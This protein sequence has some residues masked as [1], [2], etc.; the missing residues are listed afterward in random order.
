MIA[1]DINYIQN[2]FG[3]SWQ[4]NVGI[5]G[6]CRS[7]D[8]NDGPLMKAIVQDFMEAI[9]NSYQKYS[10]I[11]TNW[12]YPQVEALGLADWNAGRG[13]VW[14]LGTSSTAYFVNK[15]F[16]KAQGW[17]IG[18]LNPGE[19][20]L[21]I[22]A[23]CG[24]GAYDLALNPDY[25]EPIV[26]DLLGASSTRG[27]WAVIAPSRGT[28]I[29]GDRQVCQA[30]NKYFSLEPVEDIGTAFM[31]AQQE[32]RKGTQCECAESYNLLGDPMA[33][34]P[35][36]VLTSVEEP[37]PNCSSVRLYPNPFNP[38]VTIEY[39]VAQPSI[40]DLAIYNVAGQMA[41]HMVN[42]V[43]Q[44]DGTHKLIWNG[45]D[46]KGRKVSSG[47]YFCRLRI[48]SGYELRKAILLR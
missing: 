30:L 23:N 48:G 18:K 45:N 29:E 1:K 11:D 19:L 36:R 42:A 28:W 32:V 8:G 24:I 35:T 44:S 12:T 47:V 40:V 7:L 31:L 25:G 38:S 39:D 4:H 9:P 10:L 43:M 2:K 22:G 15:F 34:V 26:Q 16:S 14:M 6:F 20:T 46:E 27:A 37:M 33:P 17:H 3:L 5:W 41:C 21:L 13:T